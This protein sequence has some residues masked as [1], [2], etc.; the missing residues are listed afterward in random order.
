MSHR[1]QHSRKKIDYRRKP[2]ISTQNMHIS[3][4]GSETSRNSGG[5]SDSGRNGQSS[6]KMAA[7][8]SRIDDLVKDYLQFRGLS[9]SLKA[10]EIELR[11][12]KEKQFKVH[13]SV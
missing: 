9:S 7:H 10:L 2:V 11:N 6:Q 12:E 4:K 8:S 1:P 5:E 3:M 13:L